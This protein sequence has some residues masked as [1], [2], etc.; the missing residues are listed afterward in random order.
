MKVEEIWEKPRDIQTLILAVT[1]II[2]KELVNN[3]FPFPFLVPFS[4][5][6]IKRENLYLEL[7]LGFI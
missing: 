6:Q 1:C 5:E 7:T 2:Q 4:I 3:I